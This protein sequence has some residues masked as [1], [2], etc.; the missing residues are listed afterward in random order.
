[1]A[2]SDDIRENFDTAGVAFSY[3]LACLGSLTA[4]KIYAWTVCKEPL[5]RGA[6]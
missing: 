1:M 5:T 2:L 3:G 6:Y 4:G